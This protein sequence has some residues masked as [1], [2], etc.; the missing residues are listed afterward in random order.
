ML[1]ESG[2]GVVQQGREGIDL[3]LPID[4]R[5]QGKTLV[6]TEYLEPNSFIAFIGIHG[7]L[8]VVSRAVLRVVGG[9]LPRVPGLAPRL[10]SRGASLT[11]RR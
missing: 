3:L 9:G 2:I 11:W 1:E 6:P 10:R 5:D 7:P 8:E 4:L